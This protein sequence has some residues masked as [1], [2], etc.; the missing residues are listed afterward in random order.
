M[1][2]LILQAFVASRI[3]KWLGAPGAILAL[4]FVALGVY[5]LIGAG[6]GFSIM[7]WAKTAENATDYSLMN[8]GRQLLWL[9]T[10]REE[11]Y[12][13]KQ[14]IDTFFVRAGDMVSAGVVFA[15]TAWLHLGV[16]GFA[17]VNVVGVG[18]WLALGYLVV[19]SYRRLCVDCP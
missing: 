4:P 19:R 12:K 16:T 15:G 13:A 7:R 18:L 8:T 2:A 1:S 9:P 10:T 14:A 17:G 3:V 6:V 5:G 11:K